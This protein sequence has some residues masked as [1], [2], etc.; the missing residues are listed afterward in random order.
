MALLEK[1][2]PG[3][4]MTVAVLERRALPAIEVRPARSFFDFH[5]KYQDAATGYVFDIDLPSA[6]IEHVEATAVA[7]VDSLGCSGVARVDLRLDANHQPWLL[8]V[9]TIP[10]LTDHSLVPKAAQRAGIV[11]AELCE[12]LVRAKLPP[13][14]EATFTRA[15]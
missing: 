6:V 5:A 14:T 9:N 15:A 1:F 2:I 10:G 11:F 8:E 7:A 12:R 13:A 3:R 4:E